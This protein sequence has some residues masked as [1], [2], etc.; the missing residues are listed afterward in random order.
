M[1][2]AETPPPPELDGLVEAVWT[3][4]IGADGWVDH[5]AVP[6][7]CIELIRRHSGRSF[8]R[9]DQP[10][11]FV[12][13]LALRPA[14]LRFSGDARFTGIRLWPWAWHAL[15][16]APC[17][18]FADGWR[19]I[20][21]SDPLAA[22]IAGD[23][24]P[25]PRL[26]AAFRGRRPPPL[27]AIRQ[28]AGVDDLARITG[29]STRQLQRICARETGMAPRSYLRLLRFRTAVSGIQ[30]PDAALADTAAVS[31]YADQAH[32]TREFQSLGGLPPGQ[33]RMRARGPFV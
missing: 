17:N 11:L 29:L 7:G 3:L 9:T 23:P 18:D 12:T 6:D 13:G 14:V 26:I 28:S 1:H 33:A 5:Q 30:A 25:T 31:G 10:P 8:W 24:D 27:A 2:Y 32:M 16:G 4:D 22:L 21:E 15:D 20:A 19:E